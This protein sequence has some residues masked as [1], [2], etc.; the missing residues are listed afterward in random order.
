MEVFLLACKI[1]VTFCRA[2][3]VTASAFTLMRMKVFQGRIMK[4]NRGDMH[5]A[6]Q[7]RES[8]PFTCAIATALLLMLEA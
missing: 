1:N 7:C 2:Y 8:I 3:G 6:H 4:T 5:S